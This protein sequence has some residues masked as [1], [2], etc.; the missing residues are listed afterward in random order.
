MPPNNVAL[1]DT[2]TFFGYYQPENCRL[3]LNAHIT[4]TGELVPDDTVDP[5]S[6]DEPPSAFSVETFRFPNFHGPDRHGLRFTLNQHLLLRNYQFIQEGFQL[7]S[8]CTSDLGIYT[9]ASPGHQ[10][11]QVFFPNTMLTTP[12]CPMLTT[13]VRQHQYNFTFQLIR[14]R[15][16][17]PKFALLEGTYDLST[18]LVNFNPDLVNFQNLPDLNLSVYA[19][20]ASSSVRIYSIYHLLTEDFALWNDN[21]ECKDIQNWD[22]SLIP[23]SGY[24]LLEVKLDS[25]FMECLRIGE[26]PF[27]FRIALL[28]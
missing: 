24:N 27:H 1:A 5:Q 22:L 4:A 3:F 21:E 26:E 7:D 11:L 25:P 2:L 8:L 6:C 12:V 14:G 13:P 28:H 19:D 17:A 9:F 15:G 20:S 23:A 16:E 18:H 10:H